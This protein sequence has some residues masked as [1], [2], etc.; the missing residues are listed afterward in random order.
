MTR[1]YSNNGME[2]TTFDRDN[3]RVS[4]DIGLVVCTVEE[5]GGT[6]IAVTQISMNG[7]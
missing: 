7:E 2:F 3:D 5:C 4:N 1:R 6:A